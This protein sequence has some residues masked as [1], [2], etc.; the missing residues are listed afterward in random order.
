MNTG[1]D[2]MRPFSTRP[3]TVAISRTARDPSGSMPVWTT[4]STEDATVGTTNRDPMFSPASS[5]RVHIL[6]SACLAELA[7]MLA[8][9]GKPGVEGQQQVEALGGS[10]L[11]DDDARRTHPERFLDERPQVD[12]AR[13]FETRL[14]GLHRYPVGVSALQLE[15][16][17]D[18]DQPLRSRDRRGKAVEQ[19]GLAGLRATRHHDVEPGRTLASRK[20]RRLLVERAQA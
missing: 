2:S 4:R 6:T 15:D 10:H 11:A 14:P 3:V 20:S 1:S 8:M 13:A 16:L 19:C 9:P 17:L 7:W 5:G 12:A 18:R